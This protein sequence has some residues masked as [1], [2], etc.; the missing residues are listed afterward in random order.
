MG[1]SPTPIWPSIC[2]AASGI[3]LNYSL[4]PN[5]AGR[6]EF[7][8]TRGFVPDGAGFF[9][10]TDE[11]GES[12]LLRP[13]KVFPSLLVKMVSRQRLAVGYKLSND[14]PEPTWF[15]LEER[16]GCINFRSLLQSFAA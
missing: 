11:V 13:G 5:D 8:I 1:Y 15:V 3:L 10:N 6:G 14:C 12:E 4:L 9:V 2:L 16:P 7:F